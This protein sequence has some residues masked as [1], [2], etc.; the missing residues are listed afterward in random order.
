MVFDYTGYSSDRWQFITAASV[1]AASSV[2]LYHNPMARN[3]ALMLGI[4]VSNPGG[5]QEAA[6]QW[7]EVVSGADGV[8]FVNATGSANAAT[9]NAW[10]RPATLRRQFILT[11][12]LQPPLSLR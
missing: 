2:V 11:E 5:M 3:I 10:L 12:V 7:A 8:D 1:A 6:R 4:M 9:I